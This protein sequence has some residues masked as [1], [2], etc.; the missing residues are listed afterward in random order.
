MAD[1]Q[2]L[3]LF[4]RSFGF[5]REIFDGQCSLIDC[6]GDSQVVLVFQDK[7]PIVDGQRLGIGEIGNKVGFTMRNI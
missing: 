7:R 4:E 6:W 2:V 5:P 3:G 1:D